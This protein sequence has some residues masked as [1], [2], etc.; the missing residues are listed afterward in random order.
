MIFRTSRARKA[1]LPLL[2]AA[3][4]FALWG[5]EH[6]AAQEQA[7]FYLSPNGDGVKDELTV[8]F[9]MRDSRF[10]YSWAFTVTDGGGKEVY[11]RGEDVE[12]VA[13]DPKNWKAILAAFVK[14]KRSVNPPKNVVWDGKNN[15]GAAVPDGTYYFYFSAADDN[16]NYGETRRYQVIVD[17]VPPSVAVR[18]PGEGEKVFGQ[19]AKPALTI[20]QSGSREDRWVGEIRNES[21]AVVRTFEWRD[22]APPSFTWDGADNAGLALP[23]GVYRYSVGATDA[24]GNTSPP[25]GITAITYDSTPKTAE[26]G[27]ANAEVAPNGRVKTQVFTIKASD[28]G[29]VE[30]WSFRVVP[31]GGGEAA[32][33]W[34]KGDEKIPARIDWNGRLAGGGVAEGNYMGALE[35]TYANGTVLKAGTQPFVSGDVPRAAVSAAPELFSPDGDGSNDTL[36]IKLDVRRQIPIASWS[37]VIFDPNHKPFWTASGKSEVPPQLTWNGRGNDGVLVESAMDY[38][39]TFTVVDTQDQSAEVKGVITIDIMVIRDGGRLVIRVPAVT[40]R[41][42]NADFEPKSRDPRRGLSPEVIE[43]NERVLARVAAALQRFPDYRVTVEGHANSETGTEKEET[44]I[45]VPLSRRRAE[46]VRD[47]LIRLGVNESRL[48]AVGVGGGRPVSRDRKNRDNWWK[49][50]RVEFV[51]ER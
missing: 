35:I 12:E 19:G 14:P 44:E 27:R 50:R 51:L 17:T 4:V 16:G 43:K 38:P 26:A 1:G 20:T 29:R 46:F 24:A 9:T 36:L 30:S 39:Y 6:A 3:A 23:N 25:A 7:V 22:T 31:A 2:L 21:G 8:P 28:P 37:F 33:V 42:N 41:A 13:V 15:A 48:R 40:F 45:L 34:P 11:R 10:I 47:Y 18:Q 5:V 49:N 32:A